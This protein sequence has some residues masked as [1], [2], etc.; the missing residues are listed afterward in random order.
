MISEL[1]EVDSKSV[2]L[3]EA[4]YEVLVY[5]GYTKYVVIAPM[6]HPI[7]DVFQ[8]IFRSSQALEEHLKDFEVVW[9][10]YLSIF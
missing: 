1:V 3:G 9:G 8:L 4:T 7:L 10:V 6:L 5:R 2:E